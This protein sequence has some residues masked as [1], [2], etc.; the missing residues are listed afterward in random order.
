M[1]GHI[2]GFEGAEYDHVPVCLGLDEWP[3]PNDKLSEVSGVFKF[4]SEYM[5][6]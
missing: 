6:Y 5:M 3:K 4:T 1:F 2:L